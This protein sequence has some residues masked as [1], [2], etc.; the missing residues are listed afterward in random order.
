MG[1]KKFDS[2][3]CTNNS[4]NL[5]NKHGGWHVFSSI[6]ENI[7]VSCQKPFEFLSKHFSLSDRFRVNTFSKNVATFE[8]WTHP[9]N[10]NYHGLKK[11]K[12]KT[13]AHVVLAIISFGYKVSSKSLQSFI[14]DRIVGDRSIVSRL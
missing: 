11:K 1:M 2:F 7:F 9:L 14:G 12:K 6:V 10:L 3:C 4:C 8:G 13:H 5:S